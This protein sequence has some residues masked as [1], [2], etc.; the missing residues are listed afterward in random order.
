MYRLLIVDDEVDIVNSLSMYLQELK[1]VELDIY[2]AYSAYEAL[3]WLRCTKM[4]IVLSDIRMPGMDGMQLVEIIRKDW[5]M[6]KIIFVTGYD[7]FEFVHQAI[8]YGGVN[9]ILKT[10]GYDEVAKAIL[11][12]VQEIDEMMHNQEMIQSAKKHMDTVL[13]IMQKDILLAL[14]QGESFTTEERGQYFS[15]INLGLR[16]ELPVLLFIL[17]L[18]N[19]PDTISWLEKSSLYYS[20]NNAINQHLSADI[21]RI[22]IVSEH[23]NLVWFVQPGKSKID[24]ADWEHMALLVK[25]TAE[26]LQN[27]CL[28]AYNVTFS[29]LTDSNPTTW[30]TIADRYE[31]LK[32]LAYTLG[33]G[34]RMRI[35]DRSDHSDPESISGEQMRIHNRTKLRN[36]KMLE[37]FMERGEQA[38]FT[39]MFM[40]IV[41]SQT[42]NGTYYSLSLMFLSYLEQWDLMDKVGERV[43]LDKLTRASSHASWSAASKYFLDLSVV[44][45]EL[46]DNEENNRAMDS[47]N[48]V[49]SYVQQHYGEDLSL[50]R[51]G[52]V[53]HFNP[54]YL[55]RLFKQITGENLLSYINEIRID[56]AQSLLK[57][58]SLKIHEIAEKVGYLSAPSFTRFFKKALKMSPQEYRDF[59]IKN[60]RDT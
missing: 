22:G 24:S 44:I 31:S 53:V 25:G 28:K 3:E 36:L 9:Y 17:R 47:V 33:A 20:I 40:D 43:D 10:E 46:R 58:S 50:V 45:F 27:V 56:H 7:K 49:K 37:A 34:V 16:A 35:V 2:R 21:L 55:S 30:D 4:D 26:T 60:S 42:D 6:C 18:E 39:D 29:M 12:A 51:L 19:F 23:S 15:Q 11:N 41:A 48:A 5:P 54:S 32:I 8:K 59:T 13:P 57:E 14:L 1:T 38:A 52:Q